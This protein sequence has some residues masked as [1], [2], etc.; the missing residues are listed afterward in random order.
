M[1]LSRYF[2]GVL[3]LIMQILRR[4]LLQHGRLLL[5][6][7]QPLIPQVYHLQP[8]LQELSAYHAASAALFALSTQLAQTPVQRL[9]F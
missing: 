6:H 8:A 3:L 9:E 1:T 2:V 5:L 7:G 4:R